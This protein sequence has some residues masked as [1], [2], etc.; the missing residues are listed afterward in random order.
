MSF[1]MT[2]LAVL[3]WILFGVAIL[4]A[5]AL[6]LVGLFGNWIILGAV[7]VAYAISGTTYFSLTGIII[8]FVIAAIAEATEAIAAGYGAAKFGGGKGAIV[9]AIVGTILGAIIFT[10]VIPIP[11]IGTVIGACL[12]AFIGATAWELSQQREEGIDGAVRVGF[13]AALGKVAGLLAKSIAGF[14][15]L[16]VAAWTF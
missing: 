15:M 16:G 3:G 9:S 13:G 4:I 1:L 10:P 7:V 8:L 14:I 11:L 12:G 2:I 6:N 5:I